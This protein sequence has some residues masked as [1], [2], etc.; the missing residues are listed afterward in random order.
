MAAPG[1]NG[2]AITISRK[3]PTAHVGHRGRP[4]KTVVAATVTVVATFRV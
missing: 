3:S 4:A 1:G 2:F